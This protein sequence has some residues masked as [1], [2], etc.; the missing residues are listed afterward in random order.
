MTEFIKTLSFTFKTNVS[1][2]LTLSG[3][4]GTKY[5]F[6][7]DYPPLNDLKATILD[8]TGT[9]LETLPTPKHKPLI[10]PGVPDVL[11][12]TIKNI[13][14]MKLPPGKEVIL[15]NIYFTTFKHCPCTTHTTNN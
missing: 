4:H 9:S 13:L 15:R 6:N 2:E 12:A 1:G 3:G 8:A 10:K 11:E 7:I 5:F 14:E